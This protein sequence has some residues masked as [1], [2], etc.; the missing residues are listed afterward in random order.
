MHGRSATSGAAGRTCFDCKPSGRGPAL[1]DQDVAISRFQSR[2]RLILPSK[3]SHPL[4]YEWVRPTR[5]AEGVN[6]TPSSLGSAPQA[7]EEPTPRPRCRQS[8]AD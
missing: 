5:G 8:E 4:I 1:G 3:L 6:H 7:Q 2:A